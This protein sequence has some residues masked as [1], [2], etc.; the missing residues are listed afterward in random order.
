MKKLQLK[1]KEETFEE[2]F[3]AMNQMNRFIEIIFS[4]EFPNITEQGLDLYD[5]I[6]R[7]G[8]YLQV[9][10]DAPCRLPRLL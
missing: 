6:K 5:R 8:G 4:F 7:K 3:G 9:V 2:H 10:V 1:Q